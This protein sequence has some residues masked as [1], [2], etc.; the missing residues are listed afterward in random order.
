M[1]ANL[2]R[3]ELSKAQGASGELDGRLE[4]LE[5]KVRAMRD[6][7]NDTSGWWEGDAGTKFRESFGRAC[8]YFN[9]TL[10]KK[11]QAHAANMVKSVQAQVEQDSQIGAKIVRH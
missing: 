9:Q 7:V 10:T 2:I 11:L 6:K 1:M 8:E 4:E 5:A 3:V